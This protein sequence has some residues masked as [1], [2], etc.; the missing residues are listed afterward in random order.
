MRVVTRFAPSPTGPLHL[1]HAFAALFAAGA[2]TEAGGTFRLRIEDLD[3][4][5]AR[6]E[7]DAGIVRDLAWLGLSWPEPVIR[8]SARGEAYRA[9]LEHLEAAGLLYPCFCTR[10]D[11]AAAADAPQ[12][13]EGPLYPGTCRALP[14]R[15][16][17][18]RIAGGVPHALRLD[19]AK[20][21]ARAG[22][23]T[24]TE[25][26][27]GP[28]GE[29]GRVTVDPLLLGDAVLARKDAAAAYHLAVVID[30][31]FEGVTLVTRGEDLFAATHLQRL[32]QVLLG[33]PEP[34]Y[35]HHR[36]IRDEG[37]K[38]LAKR[39]GARALSTLRAEGWTPADVRRA[40]GV[41]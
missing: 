12:G 6:P 1:G 21:A 24:F 2:A 40:V 14:A 31:A 36:L 41:G 26:G 29:R 18:L 15:E 19:A 27:A 22:P 37:G 33:L 17:Q 11:I 5:R 25:S 10:A 32:L 23:L 8:Q 30:D 4:G 9:A 35:R 38:R 13:P 3:Q 39:D 16:R 20:A 28:L 7:Y 34:A